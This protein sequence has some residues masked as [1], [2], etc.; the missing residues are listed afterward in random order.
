MNNRFTNLLKNI[1][2]FKYSPG[3]LLSSDLTY[4]KFQ[5][6]FLYLIIIKDIVSKEVIAFNLSQKHDSNLVLKTIKEALL[7]TGKVPL[8]FHSD[9][10]SEYLSEECINFLQKLGISISVCD[11]GSPWQNGWSEA[12]FSSLKTESGDLNRFENLGELIEYLYGYLNYYNK[13]RIQLKLKM[14]PAKFKEKFSE[15]VLEKRGT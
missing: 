10:G 2:L 9:R 3:Q 5:G 11:P 14:S 1:N 8:I 7:K 6:R 12:F 13:E 15:S 4:I